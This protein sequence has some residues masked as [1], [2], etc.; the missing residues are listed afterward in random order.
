VAD[1]VFTYDDSAPPGERL[2][3]EMVEEI[4]LVAPAAVLPQSITTAKL[5]DGNV[6]L[7]KMAPGAVDHTIIGVKGVQTANIDDEAV[8]E[9]QLAAGAVTPEKTGTGVLT[10]FD[11]TGNP[12][13][14]TAVEISATDYAALDPPDSN[15]IYLIHA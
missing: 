5:K 3:P 10:I 7:A 2:P 15:T 11:S 14:R 12:L 8:G 1:K 13:Q 6:T 4:G 9:G